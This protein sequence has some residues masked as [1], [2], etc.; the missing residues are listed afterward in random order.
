M[1]QPD[2]LDALR[3]DPQAAQLLNDPNALRQLLSS[4]QAQALATL[5]LRAGGDSIRQAAASAARGDSAPLSSILSR[6]ASDPG[7]AKIMEDLEKKTAQTVAPQ[8]LR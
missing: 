4:P 8:G 7:G 2:P 3:Q 1:K 5:L 6:V